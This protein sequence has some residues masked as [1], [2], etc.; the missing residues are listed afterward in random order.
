[1]P[2]R[3]RNQTSRICETQIL[4]SLFD[5][6]VYFCL[7][8]CSLY[9]FHSSS[10]FP[11]FKSLLQDIWNRSKHTN[12]LYHCNITIIRIRETYI[13]VQIC[14]TFTMFICIEIQKNT[15][16]WRLSFGSGTKLLLSSLSLGFWHEERE[17]RFFYA[18]YSSFVSSQHTDS[19]NVHARTQQSTNCLASPRSEKSTCFVQV[20]ISTLCFSLKITKNPCPSL[21][22]M[23]SFTS[24]LSFPIWVFHCDICDCHILPARAWTPAL[25]SAP[26]HALNQKILSLTK[27]K[28][29][30]YKT[31]NDNIK[32]TCRNYI[33]SLIL[34]CYTFCS[35]QARSKYLSKFSISFIFIKYGKIHQSFFFGIILIFCL[36][37][38]TVRQYNMK[39]VKIYYESVSRTKSKIYL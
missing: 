8:S 22:G 19:T 9:R 15:K 21:P 29:R 10:D 33:T 35:S 12:N 38:K 36:L 11:F 13:Y 18:D 14:K 2:Q 39:V 20:Q 6:T 5:S 23:T 26:T 28:D 24:P 25:M 34:S 1:M 4:T 37:S 30:V 3:N 16:H 31:K 17:T 27:P 7:Q 32:K